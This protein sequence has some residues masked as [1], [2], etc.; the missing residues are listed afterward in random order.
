[1]DELEALKAELDHY[2]SEKERIRD[3]LGQVGGKSR[4]RRGAIIN[5][6]FL[7]LVV[8]F[9]L[10]D[11]LR[12]AMGLDMPYLPPS[13]LLEIAVLLVSVKIIWMIHVQSKVDHFQFWI[14]NSIEFRMNMISRRLTRL[15]SAIRRRESADDL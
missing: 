1:M 13:M 5:I 15:D 8:G 9:F 14:L 3:V 4:K 7:V 6:V 12:H 10:F 2:R 11:V